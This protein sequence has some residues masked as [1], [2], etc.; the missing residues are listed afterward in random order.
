MALNA[1]N[2]LKVEK[3][4]CFVVFVNKTW[5]TDHHALKIWLYGILI[6]QNAVLVLQVIIK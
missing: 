1:L 6:E 2:G 5:N 3:Y 4:A